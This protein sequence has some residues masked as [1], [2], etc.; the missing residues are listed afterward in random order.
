MSQPKLLIFYD[1]HTL[2]RSDQPVERSL[3]LTQHFKMDVIIRDNY[4]YLLKE[5]LIYEAIHKTNMDDDIILIISKY[6][7]NSFNNLPKESKQELY[8]KKLYGGGMTYILNNTFIKNHLPQI[9]GD[10][11]NN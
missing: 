10:L 6:I 9:K 5:N 11:T 7:N 2:I 8:D 3:I 4:L 1:V